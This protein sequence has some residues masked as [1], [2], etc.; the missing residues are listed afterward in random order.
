MVM[1]TP[2]LNPSQFKTNHTT[3]P[4]SSAAYDPPERAIEVEMSP[5]GAASASARAE[6]PAPPVPVLPLRSSSK[7]QIDEAMD[8][9]GDEGD[10]AMRSGLGHD[11]KHGHG[12]PHLTPE[13]REQLQ[14]LA[15]GV[16]NTPTSQQTFRADRLFNCAWSPVLGPEKDKPFLP[17]MTI[18]YNMQGF[19][20]A[21]NAPK[22]RAAQAQA[23]P[24]ATK[25]AQAAHAV[26]QHLHHTE[27]TPAPTPLPFDQEEVYRIRARF[28]YARYFSFTTYDLRL[29][30]VAMLHDT[31]IKPA[32]GKNPF[33]DPTAQ[34]AEAGTFEVYITKDGR[35]GYPNEMAALRPNSTGVYGLLSMRLQ[36]ADP[37][38]GLDRSGRN[39]DWGF[40]EMPVVEIRNPRSG[41]FEPIRR[42]AEEMQAREED[43][44]EHLDVSF[45]K[46]WPKYV[47]WNVWLCGLVCE[48]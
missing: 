31:L 6:P 39:R 45:S 35:H 12:I 14:Q 36:L 3:T 7:Q 43:F 21:S 17:D 27:P 16:A 32:K 47:Q 4:H 18:Q 11:S 23:H 29:Q 9:A 33:L 34:E 2:R 46:W 10:K 20:F 38:P 25:A 41:N 26:Q 48:V 1:S 5:D 42:C 30:S 40:V 37:R 15:A 13:Q 44:I 19:F 22:Q 28:P 24:H 8:G